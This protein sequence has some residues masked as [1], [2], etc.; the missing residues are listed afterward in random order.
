MTPEVS[1]EKKKV[2]FPPMILSFFGGPLKPRGR[3]K[4][5]RGFTNT[6]LRKKRKR[7]LSFR[8][9]II[10]SGIPDPCRQGEREGKKGEMACSIPEGEKK[11][12]EKGGRSSEI[13]YPTIHIL[14]DI[15]NEKKRKGNF[16]KPSHL[17]EL[18]KKE[19]SSGT[20][21]LRLNTSFL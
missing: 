21:F 11:R 5:E 3:G 13:A 16:R 10:H 18:E 19:P 9:E 12:K 8:K 17:Q 6:A 7:T 4:K 1:E 20:V 2:C 15:T 14:D